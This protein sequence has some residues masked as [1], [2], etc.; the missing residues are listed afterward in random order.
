MGAS[1][2]SFRIARVAKIDVRVHASF[3]GVLFAGAWQWG[4][5]HGVKGALFGVVLVVLLFL[6]VALHELGHGVVARSFHLPVG[7]IVLHP[8]GG[9]ASVDQDAPKPMQELLVAIAGPAMNVMLAAILL[10]ATS[11]KLSLAVVR[12]ETLGTAALSTPST[13]T[14]LVWLLSANVVMAVFN[15]IPALPMDGGRVLR[16]I[17]AMRTRPRTAT[18]VAAGV[19]QALSIAMGVLGVA[20]KNHALTVIALLIFFGALTEQRS[21]ASPSVLRSL[22]VG[23]VFNRNAVT[24]VPNDPVSRVVDH[25]LTS[26]Q[27]DFAV[28]DGGRLVGIVT[29]RKLLE[30][31]AEP[32]SDRSVSAIMD[33]EIARVDAQ[34]PLDE[35]HDR[36]Q[37]ESIP[38]VAVYGGDRGNRYLGLVSQ[39]DIAEAR[40]VAGYVQRRTEAQIRGS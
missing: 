24:L 33:R 28:F 20:T 2:W 32:T 13:T 26:Y 30:V 22:R 25:I 21:A 31:L 10:V 15:M 6:C 9:A 4:S 3:A 38:I 1:R 8:F 37:R 16:A 5:S 35:V 27:P 17:L 39:E 40:L 14:L 36:M 19:G 34:T 29:R 11:A 23:D 12:G 18:L 7:E